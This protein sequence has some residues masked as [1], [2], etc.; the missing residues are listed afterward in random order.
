MPAA[1]SGLAPCWGF[2]WR[3]SHAR[4]SEK[5]GSAPARQFRGGQREG[6]RGAFA[7][8]HTEHCA[9]GPGAAAMQCI[10]EALTGQSLGIFA[11]AAARAA[12]LRE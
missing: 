5:G 9:A 4:G 8:A 11:V 7:A 1:A 6:E 3:R 10:A 2:L 12:Q